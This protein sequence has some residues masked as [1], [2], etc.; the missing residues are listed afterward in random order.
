M[1]MLWVP[2]N[3]DFHIATLPNTEYGLM[4]TLAMLMLFV[5]VYLTKS[6][7]QVWP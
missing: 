6:T 4:F 5:Y 1:M 7:E 2:Y 3:V